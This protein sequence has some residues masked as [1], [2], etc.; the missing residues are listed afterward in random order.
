M[1]ALS[2]SSIAELYQ[3]RPEFGQAALL[4]HLT[5]EF[6]QAPITLYQS[7]AQVPEATANFD[8]GGV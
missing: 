2:L 4:R 5:A 6:S 3:L 8:F 1:R 7:L